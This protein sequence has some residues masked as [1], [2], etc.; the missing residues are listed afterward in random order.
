MK[1]H[2]PFGS[3]DYSRPAAS[4]HDYAPESD[5]PATGLG[6]MAIVVNNNGVVLHHRDAKPWI[7]HPDTWSLFGGAAEAGEEPHDVVGRELQ[8]ELGLVAATIRPLWR[9]V[10]REGDMRLLTIF[11]AVTS[12]RARHMTLSEGQELGEFSAE[13]ALGLNLT[14]FCRRCLI[15]YISEGRI[16]S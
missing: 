12:T 11:E 2:L 4:G 10:D 13:E 5:E 8:E 3:W 16:V 14:P 9:L 15:R 1:I 7:P 6:A